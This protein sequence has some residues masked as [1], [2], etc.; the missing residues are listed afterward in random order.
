MDQLYGTLSGGEQLDG[1][2][3]IPK[4]VGELGEKT[5]TENGT[6]D[7]SD[8]GYDGYSRVV[9]SVPNTY[10]AGDEGK[11]V[12][13]GALVS[14]TSATYTINN[15]YDTTLINSV[16][17]NVSGGSTPTLETVTKTY[18]PTTSQ[19]TET[20]TPSSG[21]DGIG[22]VDV[23]VNAIPSQYIIP[24]GTK[25]ISSNGTGIDVKA[26]E[27]A[28][29]AVP[30]SYSAADEGKVVSNGA[31]V[32]QTAHADVTPT[33][34]DQ[35]IDTTLNN[36][37]KVKG[38][39]DL[40]AG[41]IKKDVEIFGVTGSYEGGGGTEEAPFNDV[42]F[43]DYDGKC[44]YSYSASEFANLSA[45]PANPSHTG[46]TAQGWN[47]TLVDAKAHVAE[48]GFLDIGQL[49]VTSDG[50]TH[51]HIAVDNTDRMTRFIGLKCSVANSLT[52]DWGDGSATE[53]N[54]STSYS[55]YTH[56]YAS[57][58]NYEIKISV[59]S[60]TMTLGNGSA[61]SALMRNNTAQSYWS[62]ASIKA[63]E[64]GNNV[65]FSTDCFSN[66]SGCETLTI[67][68]SVSYSDNRSYFGTTGLKML[69]LPK[70]YGYTSP[71]SFTRYCGKA[72]CFAKQDHLR[73]EFSSAMTYSLKRLCVPIY[74]VGNQMFRETPNLER[75]IISASATQFKAQFLTQPYSI[76]KLIF[77]ST[78]TN[79]NGLESYFYSLKEIHCKATTPPTLSGTYFNSAPSDLV[80]YVPYSA[81]H[82]V[83]E[84]YKTASNWSTYASKMQEETQ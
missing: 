7:A 41:N 18:T 61:A 28:D 81:D 33:T 20:I 46:L 23:T 39:A 60:G 49:Y 55:V 30:N 75:F 66:A 43:W 71:G 83:L 48:H 62:Q 19:Q 17:V 9:A 76:V 44:L 10:T 5:I 35:T 31:L 26:Y 3:T 63:I 12:D 15:T 8:D 45:L 36:S 57:V 72:I 27:Y 2:L 22:E 34:S 4:T 69:I 84:T 82:S 73:G 40:V 21:Y 6:Y 24:T 77:P 32:A 53:T 1:V 80:I 65:A 64:I 54:T 59:S 52:I 11:V 70:V 67:P 56:E 37:L 74:P 79:I 58:G 47:W 13:N 51:I 78:F 25:S 29:V 68:T 14:Q 38:D 16:T 42:C 50:K